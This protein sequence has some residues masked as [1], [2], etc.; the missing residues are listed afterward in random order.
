MGAG[1][2]ITACLRALFGKSSAN[3][4]AA[5]MQ[6]QRPSITLAPR[7][8]AHSIHNRQGDSDEN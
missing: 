4:T 3:H 8:K 6:P 2:A 5:I 7:V 1:S